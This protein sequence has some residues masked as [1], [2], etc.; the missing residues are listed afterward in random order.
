MRTPSGFSGCVKLPKT[1]GSGSFDPAYIYGPTL[2]RPPTGVGGWF[3][4]AYKSCWPHSSKTTNGSWWLVR[5]GLQELLVPLFK[6]HQRELVAGSTWPTRAAGPTL[7]RPPTGV[8]GWF[9][10]AYKG[11]WSPSSRPPTGVG[12]RFDLAYKGCWP[13]SSKT[14]NGSWWLVRPRLPGQMDQ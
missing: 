1:Q 14:T 13:H 12:G 7:Q 11:C 10:P 4:S 9:D 3:D 6:D 5:P 2:Q 8:G